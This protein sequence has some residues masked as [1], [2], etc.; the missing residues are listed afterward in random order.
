[1]S[2]FKKDNNL[3]NGKGEDDVQWITVK[4]NHIPI[5]NGENPRKAIK[6]H[7]ANKNET[8]EKK[9]VKEKIGEIDTKFYEELTGKSILNNNIVVPFDNITHINNRHQD[10]YKK[11]K[12]N[13]QQIINDP[14]YV[15]QGQA[16]NRLLV[17]RKIDKNVE[18]VLE[19]SLLNKHYSNKIVSMWELSDKD[20]GKLIRKNRVLYK[21]R[22]SN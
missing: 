21:K 5:K 16:E 18:V 3:M 14:D 13:I 10:V 8:S 15:L 17:V 12:K 22:D 7:F 9:P 20:I 19:L 2:E 1:M 6:N 11:Y 4:G